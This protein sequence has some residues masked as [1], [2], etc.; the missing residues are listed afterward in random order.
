MKHERLMAMLDC[1][2]NEGRKTAAQLAERFEVSERTVYR[3]MDALSM[4][5]VPVTADSGLGG[6]YGIDPAY[7]VDRSFLSR[8]ELGDL[9][10]L[11]LG[12]SEALKDDRLA[13]SL[14]KLSSLGKGSGDGRAGIEGLPPPLV[15]TL[16]PWGIPGPDPGVVLTLRRAIADR[17]VVSFRYGDAAGRQ[18]ERRVE[19]FTLALLGPSWYVHGYCLERRAWRL[20]KLAR[21]AAIRLSPERYDPGARLPAPA[22]ASGWNDDFLAVRLAAG[23]SAAMALAEALPDADSRILP[24]G[25][26][27]LSF[28]YPS[29]DWLVRF[30][31]GFG[32]GIRV[33]EPDALRERLREKALEIADMNCQGEA[34]ILAP[35]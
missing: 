30:L 11:L 25:R 17:R 20:F 29:G 19:P 7:R 34:A 22:I 8:D 33:L 2:L 16:S 21:I 4:A 31:L 26:T 14:G 15:A 10:G 28:S 12:F 35:S 24:D 9:T 3:D 13:R 1:L 6:G 18:S 23:P 27:E 5:G 32:P